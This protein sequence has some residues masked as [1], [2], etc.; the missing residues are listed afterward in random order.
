MLVRVSRCGVV[1]PGRRLLALEADV[2]P[3]TTYTRS[4]ELPAEGQLI[5][6]VVGRGRDQQFFPTE[7]EGTS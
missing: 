4:E 6:I 7:Y 1:L 5:P 3:V 2:W